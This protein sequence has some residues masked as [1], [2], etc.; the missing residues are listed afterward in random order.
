[1]QKCMSALPPEADIRRLASISPGKRRP[2][3]AF[4]VLRRVKVLRRWAL[5][6]LPPL[7]CRLIAFP[8]EEGIVATLKST[9]EGQ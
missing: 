1:M 7:P 3:P 8:P 5:T 2:R 6:A 4:G 9:P